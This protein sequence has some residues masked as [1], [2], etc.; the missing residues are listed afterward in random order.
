MCVSIVVVVAWLHGGCMDDGI[1]M[2]AYC[3]VSGM[4]TVVGGDEVFGLVAG[5]ELLWASERERL[6]G[7]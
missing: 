2:G 5:G 7:W 6:E 1:M 3:V 4:I